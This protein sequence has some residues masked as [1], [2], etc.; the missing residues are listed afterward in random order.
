[1][2]HSFTKI[3][4]FVAVVELGSI[5]AASEKLDLDPSTVSRQLSTLEA[6]LDVLLI[7]RSTRKLNITRVGRKIFE[8][9]KTVLEQLQQVEEACEG[10]HR[11]NDIFITMPGGYGHYA[12]MPLI[13][14]YLAAEPHVRIHVDWSDERRDMIAGGIDVGIRGGHLPSDKV[15]AVALAEL[16]LSFIASPKVL[17][18]HGGPETFEDL[19]CFPWIKL[20]APGKSKLPPL[21][22]GYQ[23]N[24]D[25][26]TNIPL[27]VSNQEA[28]IEAVMRGLGIA[29]VE[30]VAVAEQLDRGELVE[31]FADTIHP[32]GYYWLYIPEGRRIQP[33]IRAFYHYLIEHLREQAITQGQ[34]SLSNTR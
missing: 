29:V 7:R 23:L 3:N 17:K 4:T 22:N 2:K 24:T 14:D 12:V 19:N 31:L 15:V 33:H 32:V 28:A 5:K 25:L 30:R 16:K 1:M 20:N 9:Y 26:V 34:G 11:Q 8:H 27:T 21:R 18:R 10:A 6:E 13:Q